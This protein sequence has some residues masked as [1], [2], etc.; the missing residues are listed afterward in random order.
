MSRVGESHLIILYFHRSTT[1]RDYPGDTVCAD[2]A[3]F[4]VYSFGGRYSVDDIRMS[5]IV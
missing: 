2:L 1:A 3:Y 4:S 5:N